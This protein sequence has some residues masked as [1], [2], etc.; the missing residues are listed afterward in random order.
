VIYAQSVSA[1]TSCRRL[2][3]HSAH[4]DTFL[5]A[6]ADV[7]SAWVRWPSGAVAEMAGAFGLVRASK[8][9]AL[10]NERI[11]QL[12]A[13]RTAGSCGVRIGRCPGSSGTAGPR[14]GLVLR[15]RVRIRAVASVRPGW[16]ANAG[17][18]R[19]LVR[20]AWWPDGYPCRGLA[21]GQPQRQRR[22]GGVRRGYS[23]CHPGTRQ[24]MAGRQRQPV[25]VTCPAD[26]VP[27][28]RTP[29]A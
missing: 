11:R 24:D 9:Y 28:A 14:R 5:H 12:P 6:E 19:S 16:S 10:G 17:C 1:E 21:A 20:P 22:D 13:R 3:T 27:P 15:E 26:P 18:R 7:G 2:L 25:P 23:P 4:A 29:R 8:G